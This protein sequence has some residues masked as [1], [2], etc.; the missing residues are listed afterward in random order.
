MTAKPNKAW[1]GRIWQGWFVLALLGSWWLQPTFQARADAAIQVEANAYQVRFSESVMFRL[2]VRAASAIKAVTLYYRLVGEGLTVKVPLPVAPGEKEFVHTWELEPGDVPVGARIEY[3]WRVVDQAGNELRTPPQTIAYDDTRFNWTVLEEG[4]AQLFS[5]GS[6]QGEARRLLGY[7][8]TA[9]ARLQDE[10]G[11]VLLEPVRIYVYETK[12]DMSLALPRQSEAYDD[13][14]LT[15]GVVVDEGTLLILVSHPDVE[16]TMAHELSHVVVGLATDNPYVSLPRWLDEGLAMYSE[17][18]LPA[19]NRRALEDAVGRDQLISVR[20]LSGYTSDPEQVNLFY[21]EAYSLVQYLLQ[22][23][24]KAKMAEV[25]TTFQEGTAQEQALQRVYGFGV[26]ELDGLWRKSLGL[27]PRGTSSPVQTA[28]PPPAQRPRVPC[29]GGL[30]AGLLSVAVVAR[31][32]GSA[33]A[34]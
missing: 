15:L 12:S 1:W 33:R 27:Q 13:R 9:L 22:T 30:F 28:T 3:D 16:G 31:R 6:S 29:P 24:G 2:D 21:G 25:L 18:E 32:R 5:Y 26:D 17:G 11:V 7:A 8:T 10:M 20:S 14:I 19:G 4:N 23:Y 34:S